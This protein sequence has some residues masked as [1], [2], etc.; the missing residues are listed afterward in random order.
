M[1]KQK[2]K[3]TKNATNDNQTVGLLN[4]LRLRFF[5]CSSMHS[6]PVYQRR[7]NGQNWDSWTPRQ[8]AETDKRQQE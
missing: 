5:F 1:H 8:R 3:W 4:R 7:S 2:Q 6:L